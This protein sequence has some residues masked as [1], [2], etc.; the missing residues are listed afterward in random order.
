MRSRRHSLKAIISTNAMISTKA[1]KK[2]IRALT[3]PKNKMPMAIM[4]ITMKA[5]MSGSASNSDPTTATAT[6]MGA[7]ALKNFSFTSILRTM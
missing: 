6:P 1:I 4:A 7:T 2:N 3:P 5:P